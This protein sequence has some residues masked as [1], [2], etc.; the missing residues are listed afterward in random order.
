MH[1]PI[2]NEKHQQPCIRFVVENIYRRRK[3]TR[4]ASQRNRKHR[5]RQKESNVGQ[6]LDRRWQGFV[7]L[8]PG[9]VCMPRGH[10]LQRFVRF[11]LLVKKLQGEEAIHSVS[12]AVMLE[13]E[14]VSDSLRVDLVY[15]V[16]DRLAV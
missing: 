4:S 15:H 5:G 2:G 12:D 13:L 16:H 3:K 7:R 9:G 6:A 8:A 10:L 1:Y 14:F 11:Y